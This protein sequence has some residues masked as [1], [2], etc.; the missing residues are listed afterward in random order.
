[1]GHTSLT[2]PLLLFLLS[3]QKPGRR[4][5]LSLGWATSSWALAVSL[6][7]SS[8]FTFWATSGASGYGKKNAPSPAST[9]RSD[10]SHGQ[11]SFWAEPHVLTVQCPLCHP[12]GPPC[13]TSGLFPKKGRSKGPAREERSRENPMGALPGAL[14]SG[15]E[16]VHVYEPAALCWG[17]GCRYG[18]D[19]SFV[20]SFIC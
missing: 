19:H 20:L 16:Y 17:L 13:L 5:H 12:K 14:G 8:W 1:M 7:L 2:P 6:V 18:S 15:L 10:I 11:V 3:G 9:S 4:S